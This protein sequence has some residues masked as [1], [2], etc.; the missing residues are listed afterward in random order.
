MPI[1]LLTKEFRRWIKQ[2]DIDQE[3]ANEKTKRSQHFHYSNSNDFQVNWIERLLQTGIADGRKESLRLILGP[4]LT[5]RKSHEET[6]TMLQEWLNKCNDVKP[7]DR[8]FN[9]K[10]RINW[11]LRNTHGFLKSENLKA[12][13]RW[14]YEAINEYII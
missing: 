4:Y 6:A 12:K 10:Q 2:K 11:A 7:L 1:Q 14:L 8:D 3:S 13:Y 5:K 9:P